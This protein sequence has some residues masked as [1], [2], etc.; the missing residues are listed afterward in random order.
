MTAA[1]RG[2]WLS[3]R[4]P[5]GALLRYAS[6]ARVPRPPARLPW[7]VLL[8][9]VVGSFIAGI[10]VSVTSL[11]PDSAL[12]LI[13]ARRLRRRTDDLQHVQCRDRATRAR[14][15]LADG[16]GSVLGNVLGGIF[17]F[18]VAWDVTAVAVMAGSIVLQ[19]G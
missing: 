12:R 13:V 7:A 16:A 6:R 14:G 9:N 18:V 2:A 11:D 15:A 4:E 5:L 3:S 1:D 10:V 8:V 17:A 19:N